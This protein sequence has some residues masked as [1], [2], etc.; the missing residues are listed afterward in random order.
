M[1]WSWRM[2]RPSS[3]SVRIATTSCA[4]T[5]CCS[6]RR[7][8]VPNIGL[9]KDCVAMAP[10]PLIAWGQRAPMAKALVVTATPKAPL[11]ASR[12]TIDHVIASPPGR[13]PPIEL[14]CLLRRHEAR[15]RAALDGGG[16]QPVDAEPVADHLQ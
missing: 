15:P 16:D 7:P 13:R 5:P 14:P 12:A 2:A 10:T 8:R 4:A 9:V 3:P 11:A 6:R 1:R